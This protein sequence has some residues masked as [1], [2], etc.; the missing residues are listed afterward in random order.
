M[1]AGPP[2]FAR[3][4]RCFAALAGLAGAMATVAGAPGA[5]AQQA[6]AAPA[7]DSEFEAGQRALNSVLDLRISGNRKGAEAQKRIDALSDETDQLA[8]Q[9]RTTLKQITAIEQYSAS[10]QQL[11]DAQQIEL[12]SL[13][14]QLN[15][16]AE[17]GRNV[18]PL[19][20]RMIDA[21]DRFVELDVP[22]LIDERRER[23]ADLRVLLD[24]ADITVA[25]KFRQILEAYQ[26]EN[27]YGRTIEA[28][29]AEIPVDGNP[30]TVD[31]LRVGRIALVYQTLD[32]SQSGA[33]DRESR[34]WQSLGSEY[35][36]PARLGLRV[37]RQLEPPDLI[38][39]PV[40][41][42]TADAGAAGTETARIER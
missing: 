38:E 1:R 28:Y 17:V 4:L 18:T 11:V 10:M 9:Y 42:A 40:P 25:T 39:V 32:G 6:E 35:S 30:T 16:V 31:L 8:A 19:M 37:A 34:S 36:E 2:H 33:W 23:I 14:D 12:D 24:R 26:L 20:L 41:P 27:E 22:F 29:R 21:L 15:R 5:R 7:G 3:A 13:T